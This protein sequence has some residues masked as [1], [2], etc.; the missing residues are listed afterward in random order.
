MRIF[1]LILAVLFP[2][3]GAASAWIG[4]CGGLAMI[5]SPHSAWDELRRQMT[6]RGLPP[7]PLPNT[8]P[9]MGGNRS[10]PFG[11]FRYARREFDY[12]DVLPQ[13]KRLEGGTTVY[14]GRSVRHRADAE[15]VVRKYFSRG[16]A[17][18]GRGYHYDVWDQQTS[19]EGATTSG[20]SNASQWFDMARKFAAQDR[21]AEAGIVFI[22][23]VTGQEILNVS[24]F[25]RALGLPII[26]KEEREIIIKGGRDPRTV[27]A[28]IVFEHGR[29]VAFYTNP[30]FVAR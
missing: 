20:F 25:K 1:E 21:D 13:A 30:N 9:A 6:T 26:F 10:I 22:C 4:S 28:A 5:G 7:Q 17:R 3:N 19:N 2:I 16:V 23:D 12:A 29:P 11:R 15:A 24:A 27:R 8:P 14:Y 18:K